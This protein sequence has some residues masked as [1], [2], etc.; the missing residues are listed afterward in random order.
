MATLLGE[1]FDS[2]DADLP[3]AAV[4]AML[5]EFGIS[6]S[7]ARSALSR[8]AR[9]GLIAARR[10]GR[11]VTYHVTP[12]AMASHRAY[13]R[14]FLTFGAEPPEWT[15]DWT[16][17]AFSLPE[18]GQAH[19]HSVRRTLSSLGF[20]RLYDSVW[21]RPGRDTRAASRAMADVLS[22]VAH[23]RWS[24]VCARFD[25][26]AG[27][28]GPAAA[29]DLDG[30]A[31]AYQNFI[32]EYR[33]LRA[34]VHAGEVDAARAFIVRTSVMDSWRSLVL[35]D[36]DLPEHLLPTP[37][38]RPRAREIFLDIHATLGPL[39]AS[40]LVEITTPYWP[41]AASWVTHFRL[42]AAPMPGRP[43]GAR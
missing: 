33:E 17:V 26:E 30:L 40:R 21:M 32:D 34:A 29:Y 25:D 15:G 27:P 5:G 13:L 39:A 7:S 28:H 31:V 42:A 36:P 9:R 35:V 24:V 16:V 8:L 14:R 3:S 38:P 19:R 1:Y 37:W 43:A 6:E 22:D 2:P 11:R 41:A 4:V 20:V 12:Q 18:P 23:A 10:P